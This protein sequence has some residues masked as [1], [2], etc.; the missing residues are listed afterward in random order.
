M[1]G[2]TQTKSNR[3]NYHA[4]LNAYDEYGKRRLKWVDTK[5]PKAGNNKR[6]ANKKFVEI[7]VEYDENGVDLTKDMYFSDFM[8]H[9]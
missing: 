1:T 9:G 5:I 3:K 6:L 4:V 7:L 2:S 8:E